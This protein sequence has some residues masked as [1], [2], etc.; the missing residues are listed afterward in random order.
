MDPSESELI[1]ALRDAQNLAGNADGYATT[2]E[3]GEAL[4]WPV[5]RIR[6]ELGALKR[7]GLLQASR[8]W[9]ERL[10]GRMTQVPVYRLVTEQGPNSS[11]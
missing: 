1:Q 5:K 10:D 7:R 8:G 11:E 4:G 6:E 3:L 2:M 9:R